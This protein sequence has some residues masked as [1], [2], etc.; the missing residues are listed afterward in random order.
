MDL[1]LSRLDHLRSRRRSELVYPNV[2][3][4]YIQQQQLPLIEAA[5]DELWR[6]QERSLSYEEIHRANYLVL[7]YGFPTLAWEKGLK[8]LKRGARNE[9]DEA[10]YTKVVQMISDCM[11]IVEAKWALRNHWPTIVELGDVE[12]HRP[13]ARVC[14]RIRRYARCWVVMRRCV[15]A[16]KTHQQY[17]PGGVGWAVT[18]E[19]FEDLADGLVTV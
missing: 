4:T 6:N 2:T 11:R 1:G 9:L 10:R 5:Y 8:A 3:Y 14:R 19:H 17:R 7:T 16:W 13:L 15:D 18:K 12:Y